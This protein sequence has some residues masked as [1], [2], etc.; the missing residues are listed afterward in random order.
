[1]SYGNFT[2]KL[3]SVFTESRNR[4]DQIELDLHRGISLE[5]FLDLTD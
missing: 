5:K 2:N 3:D 1:M 4:I